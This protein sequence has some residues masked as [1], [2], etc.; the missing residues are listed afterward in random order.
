[1]KLYMF[2]G[3]V[4][5][6]IFSVTFVGVTPPTDDFNPENPGWNG[7]SIAKAE[8]NLQP[9]SIGNIG[10]LDPSSSA[11][12][13]IG[14]SKPITD[15]EA[16]SIKSYVSR[17]GFLILADDFGTGNSL[18]EKLGVKFRLSGNL[19]MDPLFK[20]RGEVLPKIVKLEGG[21][22]PHA[23]ELV[24]NY[25]TTIEGSSFRVLAYSSSFSY[26]DLSLNFKHDAGEPKRTIP[27]N[28]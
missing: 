25:A 5:A 10:R 27:R 21:F 2:L 18:L 22:V 26:L 3:F 23:R 19:L 8:L 15:G 20:E 6:L 1:M 14:P 12:L 4:L 11:L 7:M 13:I 9:V 16:E 28:S 17:G 24:L